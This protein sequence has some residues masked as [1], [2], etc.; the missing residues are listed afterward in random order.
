MTNKKLISIIKAKIKRAKKQKE[1]LDSI[2]PYSIKNPAT[3]FAV[4]SIK[5]NAMLLLYGRLA[6]YREI[7]R[8]LKYNR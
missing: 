5:Q 2:N 1:G 7:Y 4:R 3:R 6:A 8:E